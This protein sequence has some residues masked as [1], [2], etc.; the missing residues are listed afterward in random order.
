AT[1][2]TKTRAPAQSAR[3]KKVAAMPDFVAPQLGTVVER[4]PGGEGWCHEIKFD[5]YRVQ[6][7]IEDGDAVLY[8]RKGLDWTDKFK[9]I[10]S[11]AKSLPD[12]LIDGEIVALDHNGAPDFSTLQAALSDGDSESLI[13]YAFDL[14]FAGSEDLRSLPLAD[15]KA[16]LKRLLKARKG[17]QKQ[18]RYV[19][20]FES[21][22]D[23]V[24]QSACKMELEGIVSKKLDVPYRS[25][26]SESWTKAKCR[27][28][29]EVVLGCWKTTNRKFRCLLAGGYRGGHLPLFCSVNNGSGKAEIR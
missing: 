27:A 7:R 8:T 23:A 14:L 22:G 12:M 15:R 11:E 16:R 5:G 2:E 26:R 28:G 18:I 4:P 24:L 3:P 1:A 17:K 9:A 20:H 10:A 19:E 21:G 29:Y 25:G 6:L 13:F